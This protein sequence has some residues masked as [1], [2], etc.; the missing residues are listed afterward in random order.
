MIQNHLEIHTS[1]NHETKYTGN[2]L[3]NA[4]KIMEISLEFCQFD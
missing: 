1:K 4:G 2:I 3:K